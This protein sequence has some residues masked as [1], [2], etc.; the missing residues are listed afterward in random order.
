MAGNS[1]SGGQNR[2]PTAMKIMEGTFRQDRANVNEPTPKPITFPCPPTME[3]NEFGIREWERST[4]VLID[5]GVL[6]DGDLSALTAMCHQF[7]EFVYCDREIKEKTYLKEP[8]E[9]I[10]DMDPDQRIEYMRTKYLAGR[11]LKKLRKEHLDA[12]SKLAQQFGLTP[13]SR[14]RVSAQKKKENDPLDDI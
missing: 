7:G 13:V 12:Y 10:I 4:R 11:E 3:L 6:T 8:K 1:N 14:S 5:L 2:K 9:Y